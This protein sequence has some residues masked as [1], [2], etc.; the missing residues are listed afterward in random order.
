MEFKLFHE[1]WEY[2]S[3]I[4]LNRCMWLNIRNNIA[5]NNRDIWGR[6]WKINGIEN[7]III[8]SNWHF[9]DYIP[10]DR[11][12]KYCNREVVLPQ[13][14]YVGISEGFIRNP[15]YPRFYGGQSPCRWKI[16]VSS[17][18]RIQLTILDISVIG[19]LDIII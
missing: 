3:S 7:I 17:E 14:N 18:Q 6:V 12:V 13:P 1:N 19:E 8:I 11:V 15:G 16:R 2:V 4:F 5:R 10:E 9:I